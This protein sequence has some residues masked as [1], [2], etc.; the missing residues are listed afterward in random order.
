MRVTL[1]SSVMSGG[2]ERDLDVIAFDSAMDELAVMN[3]RSARVVE[4][5]FFG[6][7]SLEEVAAVLAV[8]VATVEREWAEGSRAW[9][10]GRLRSGEDR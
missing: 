8:S 5:R 4:L 6:G 9:L 7:L 3:P 10:Y 2:A 1:D